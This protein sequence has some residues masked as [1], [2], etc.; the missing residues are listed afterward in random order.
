MPKWVACSLRCHVHIKHPG[1]TTVPRGLVSAPRRSREQRVSPW[2]WR[3]PRPSARGQE[4]GAVIDS[5]R[6]SLQ[7]LRRRRGSASAVLALSRPTPRRHTQLSPALREGWTPLPTSCL[8]TAPGPCGPRPLPP[9][10]VGTIL[11]GHS[12][13]RGGN[14]GTAPPRARAVQEASPSGLT[15][16][17]TIGSWKAFLCL[18]L[19]VCAASVTTQTPRGPCPRPQ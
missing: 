1:H 2:V 10:Q 14:A 16:P 6:Q 4:H 17:L 15:L 9:G 18:P 12:P 8:Q 19:A 13:Q 7:A 11:H 5:C 3:R